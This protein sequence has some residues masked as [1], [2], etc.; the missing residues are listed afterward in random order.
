MAKL[1]SQLP[2]SCPRCDSSQN[3]WS[4][5][6]KPMEQI[7]RGALVE[8]EGPISNCNHC[9]LEILTDDQVDQLFKAA[10]KL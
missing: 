3:V 8:L 4:T 2:Q 9:G 10:A 6:I 5:S 7:I 1:E